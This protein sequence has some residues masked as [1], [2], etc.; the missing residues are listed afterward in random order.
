MSHNFV[1]QNLTNQSEVVIF[2]KHQIQ[3]LTNR[4]MAYIFF[5]ALGVGRLRDFPALYVGCVLSYASCNRCDYSGDYFYS[6]H[7]N[8]HDACKLNLK[9]QNYEAVSQNP[10]LHVVNNLASSCRKN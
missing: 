10:R 4:E 8:T 3:S 7:R 6:N 2:L 9:R 5:P 1:P